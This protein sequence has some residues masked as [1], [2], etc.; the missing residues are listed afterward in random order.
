M[1]Q[2]KDWRQKK[3]E[4]CP[5]IMEEEWEAI[6][7]PSKNTQVVLGMLLLNELRDVREELGNLR[8]DVQDL[9]DAVRR[10]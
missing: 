5:R 10:G 8:D 7:D 6:E 1:I 9:R 2:A 4:L 3:W